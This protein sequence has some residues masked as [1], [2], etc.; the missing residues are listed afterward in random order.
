VLRYRLRVAESDEDRQTAKDLEA[1]IFEAA[2]GNDPAELA[3]AYGAYEPQSHFLLVEDLTDGVVPV[4]EMRIIHCSE[5]RP[6]RTLD[7]VQSKPWELPLDG[8]LRQTGIVLG[9]TFD[10]ATIG[11]L[12]RSGARPDPQV[13]LSLYHGLWRL[14]AE[15]GITHHTAMLDSRPLRR[16]TGIGVPFSLLP[17]AEPA[18]YMGSPRTAPVWLSID[19]LRARFRLEAISQPV[20]DTGAFPDVDVPQHWRAAGRRAPSPHV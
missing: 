1:S 11:A 7:D 6:G 19:D 20:I 17:G 8:I 4:G 10:V 13:A 16:L 9:R 14:S 3:E 5:S 2:Y 15:Q 12:A 18:E